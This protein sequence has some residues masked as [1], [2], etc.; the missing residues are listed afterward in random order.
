[1]ML[2]D[3]P[4]VIG[5][6]ISMGNPSRKNGLISMSSIIAMGVAK[7]INKLAPRPRV[8]SVANQLLGTNMSLTAASHTS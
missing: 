1:M 2:M 3:A 6:M 7:M 5:N 4:D 8:M